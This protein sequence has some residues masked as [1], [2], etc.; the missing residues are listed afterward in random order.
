MSEDR[1]GVDQEPFFQLSAEP[2][3]IIEVGPGPGSP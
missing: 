3:F 2:C 1:S